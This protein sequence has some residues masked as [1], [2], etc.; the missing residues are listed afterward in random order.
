[1]NI[2]IFSTED[3]HHTY[4]INK[5]NE[6]YPINLVVYERRRL[7]KDYDTTNPYQV[8]QDKFEKSYFFSKVSNKIDRKIKII[9]VKSINSKEVS[10][11]ALNFKYDIVIVFGCGKINETIIRDYDN[12]IINI[13]RGLAS[14]YRGLDSELWAIK[15]YDFQSIGTTIHYIDKNLDTGD[16]VYQKRL[17]LR[18]DDQIYKLRA[19][20]TELAVE[21]TLKFINDLI[22][23][24]VVKLKQEKYGRYY[25]SMDLL[26]KKDCEKMF[27]NYIRNNCK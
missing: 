9:K 27:Q 25:S 6:I 26:E 3:Y 14:K 11:I 23:Q 12:K 20:T 18:K 17:T 1:M 10:E 19:K 7:K 21:G 8:D 13:H 16:I 15:N 2:I 24:K 22:L 4:Y 5:I